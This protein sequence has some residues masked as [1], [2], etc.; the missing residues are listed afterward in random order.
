MNKEML[1]FNL[2]YKGVK[3][4]LTPLT[5]SKANHEIGIIIMNYGYKPEKHINEIRDIQKD[6]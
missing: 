5:E 3:L 4:N 6:S 1:L 2:C